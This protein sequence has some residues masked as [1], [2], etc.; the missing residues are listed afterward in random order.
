MSA[1]YT[2]TIADKTFNL[3]RSQIEHDSPN[4]FTSHFLDSSDPFT[5]RPLKI[6]RDPYLFEI[7]MRYLNGYQILPLHPNL[8]PSYCTPATTLVDLRADAEFYQ[9]NGL[10]RLLSSWKSSEDELV[11]H[12]AEIT[13]QYNTGLDNL[14]PTDSIEKIADGFS[15]EPSSE[16]K[17]QTASQLKDF[18]TVPSNA[19]EG[20]LSVFY[21][22]LLNER[23]VRKVLQRD[24]KANPVSNWEVLGWKRDYP[25][26]RCRRTSIFVKIWNKFDSVTNGGN[27]ELLG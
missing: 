21:S 12:Y 13:G 16:Q 19:K 27:L 17:Y 18:F 2:L 10:S 14:E 1:E 7:I 9:L 24:R 26:E 15:L 20:H 3:S 6:S 23:V 25:S 11:V 22:G 8:V 4:L 5:S